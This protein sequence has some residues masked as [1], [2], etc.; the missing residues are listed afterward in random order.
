[1]LG[2]WTGPIDTTG[3]DKLQEV[4]VELLDGLGEGEGDVSDA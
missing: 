3:L 4:F 2:V 1:V